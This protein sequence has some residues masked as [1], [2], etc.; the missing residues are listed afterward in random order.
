MN[1]KDSYGH[2]VGIEVTNGAFLINL[3]LKNPTIPPPPYA[4]S[5]DQLD[6]L[7]AACVELLVDFVK[8]QKSN[9]SRAGKPELLNDEENTMSNEIETN[10][11]EQATEQEQAEATEGKPSSSDAGTANES[12]QPEAGV[13]A[14][15]EPATLDAENTQDSTATEV[16]APAE[17][18]PVSGAEEQ[19]EATTEE[20]V[21]N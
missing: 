1:F 10:V 17:G 15:G 5:P 19:T 3:S 7:V 11:Q 16:S 8:A 12:T 20:V 4:L 14:K 21:P 6:L 2:T 13:P 18:E 9:P